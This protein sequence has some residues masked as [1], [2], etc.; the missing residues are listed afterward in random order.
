[1]AA[2]VAGHNR[3]HDPLRRIN[4]FVINEE[5]K[6]HKTQKRQFQMYHSDILSIPKQR[7]E[8]YAESI[9][10]VRKKNNSEIPSSMFVDKFKINNCQTSSTIQNHRYDEKKEVAIT[11]AMKQVLDKLFGTRN[12]DKSQP[13]WTRTSDLPA[14]QH[15]N[16]ERHS[17]NSPRRSQSPR[18]KK[19]RFSEIH[20]VYAN[21]REDALPLI[22]RQRSYI[23]YARQK[24]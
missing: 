11:P 3:L 21:R 6:A 24:L 1:M 19:Q 5:A 14:D 7:K 20:Q 17:S 18:E 16:T 4:G 8:K 13:F 15:A 12:D 10:E 23:N 22:E 2:S 9:E